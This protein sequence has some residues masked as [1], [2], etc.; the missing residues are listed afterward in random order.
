MVLHVL[1]LIY[2]NISFSPILCLFF[3]V[4]WFYA[5]SIQFTTIYR[6]NQRISVFLSIFSF[7]VQDTVLY[8][9]SYN[10]LSHTWMHCIGKLH[11]LT[12]MHSKNIWVKPVTQDIIEGS[13]SNDS[14]HFQNLGFEGGGDRYGGGSLVKP[15][16]GLFNKDFRNILSKSRIA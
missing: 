5:H 1:Y 12:H 10:D 6:F 3:K 4:R 7:Y 14:S 15:S 2:Q 8:L 11:H 16:D 9:L 13:P